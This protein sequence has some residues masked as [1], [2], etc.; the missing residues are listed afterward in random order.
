VLEAVELEIAVELA[1]EH[2]QDVLVELGG[3]AA[4]V[5]VGG[6]EAARLLD[7][8]GAEQD[9]VARREQGGDAA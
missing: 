8:V 7:Q 1:V 2:P 3:D 4:G 6:L 5:V 9:P